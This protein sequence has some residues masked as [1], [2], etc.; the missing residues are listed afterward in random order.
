MKNSI[1]NAVLAAAV[2]GAFGFAPT[3]QADVLATS[4]IELNNLLF[5]RG[6]TTLDFTQFLTATFSSNAD[7][8]ASFSGATVSGTSNTAPIDLSLVCSGPGCATSGLTE[9][10]FQA[11]TAPTSGSFAAADQLEAGA[12]VTNV[13]VPGQPVGTV[14]P[15]PAT[16]N[17]GS[18]AQIK[19]PTGG[20]ASATSNNGLLASFIFA[21]GQGGSVDINYD[22]DWYW[23]FLVTGDEVF[24][25][26]AQSTGQVQWTLRQVIGNVLI[27]NFIP[28]Q[29]NWTEGFTALPVP[30]GIDVQGCS[31]GAPCNGTKQNASFTHTTAN[32]AA[33]TLY[34]LTATLETT[35]DVQ[36]IPEPG[37]LALLGVALLGLFG[38]GRRKLMAK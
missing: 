5:Q 10:G 18:W 25:T 7:V 17:S 31:G 37:T 9:N 23:E 15:T 12:P 30:L 32:L 27:D 26:A 29:L 6:G 38:I 34:S 22:A 28:A 14:F 4:V 3:A 19:S 11:L 35:A 2:A 1:R 21:L 24:P 13:P 8:T 33:G 16:V 20:D 36:R